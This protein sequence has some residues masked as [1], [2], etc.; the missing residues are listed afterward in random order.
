MRTR[1]GFVPGGFAL[2][3]TLTIRDTRPETTS[4]SPL[5]RTPVCVN[6]NARAR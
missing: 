4:I 5:Y 6:V 1:S 3:L 2:V